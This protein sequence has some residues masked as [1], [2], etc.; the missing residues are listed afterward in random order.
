MELLSVK[1]KN[2]TPLIDPI[3]L[4]YISYQVIRNAF[5]RTD[6]S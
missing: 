3:A 2:K 4:I 6:L 5:L 1:I